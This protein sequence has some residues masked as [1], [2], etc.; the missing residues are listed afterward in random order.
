LGKRRKGGG[1]TATTA[2]RKME[3][4]EGRQLHLRQIEQPKERAEENV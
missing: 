3:E 4:E 2:M 1:K